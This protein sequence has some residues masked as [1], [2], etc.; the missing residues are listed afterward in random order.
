MSIETFEDYLTIDDNGDTFEITV[1][2]VDGPFVVDIDI[3]GIVTVAGR[4]VWTS[5]ERQERL[6]EVAK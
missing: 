6:K 2:G 1:Q 3:C 5:D 4:Q